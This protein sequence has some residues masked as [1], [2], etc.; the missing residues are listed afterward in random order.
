MVIS[1]LK[2]RRNWIKRCSY[3]AMFWAT[4]WG[5]SAGVVLYF[6]WGL[7]VFSAVTVGLPIW[8]VVLSCCLPRG[9]FGEVLCDIRWIKEIID[10]A[11][12][13]TWE[14]RKHFDREY[15][16]ERKRRQSITSYFRMFDHKI[17]SCCQRCSRE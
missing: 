5:T 16:E 15:Q 7:G 3:R 10:V 11:G 8:I 9:R 17:V 2:K 13:I 12:D 1:Q 14:I 6:Y 4:F